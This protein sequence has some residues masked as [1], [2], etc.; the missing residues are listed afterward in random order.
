MAWPSAAQAQVLRVVA[1][2]RLVSWNE[3]APGSRFP[4][5]TRTLSSVMSACHTELS[6]TFPSITC[7]EYPGDPFFTTN[8]PTWPSCVLRAQTTTRSATAPR[9]IHRLRPFSTQP[10]PSGRAE[11]SGR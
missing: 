8:A 11:V 7:A 2:T 3:R 1:S 4:A 10:P 9:P 6:D 5:G